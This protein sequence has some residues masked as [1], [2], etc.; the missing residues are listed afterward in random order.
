VADE[1]LI[2]T[3]SDMTSHKKRTLFWIFGISMSVLMLL[4]FVGPPIPYKKRS[5]YIC[6]VTASTRAD[7]T[8]FGL[9]TSHER[10][11]SFLE[12]WLKQREPSFQPNWQFM[13][14]Q[15]YYVWGGHSCGY[16]GTPDVYELTTTL[17]FNGTQKMSDSQIAALVETLR[18][19]PAEARKQ[20]IR[21]FSD[22]VLQ[23]SD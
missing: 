16:G 23:K 8:W 4:A 15:T 1:L 7:V 11:V 20:M 6:S 13:S 12:N 9:F 3:L 21:S 19:D 22:E 17:K 5:N 18:H 2:T 10:T 14:G